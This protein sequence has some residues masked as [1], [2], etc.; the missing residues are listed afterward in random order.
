MLK[1]VIIKLS[2]EKS[3]NITEAIM[4]YYTEILRNTDW[5]YLIDTTDLDTAVDNVINTI[6]N[7]AE[8]AIPNKTVCTTRLGLLDQSVRL[9]ENDY[10]YV[11]KLSEQIMK[12]I[13]QIIVRCEINVLVSLEQPRTST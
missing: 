10:G 1:N 11:I 9:L 6:F 2:K 3:G 7:A 13:G 4:N 8:I 5:D 12:V